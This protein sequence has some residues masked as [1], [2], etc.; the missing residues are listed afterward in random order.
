M[1]FYTTLAFGTAAVAQP[2]VGLLS[3]SLIRW[4]WSINQARKTVQ[5]GLQVLSATIIVT[6]LDRQCR[7]RHLL[8]GAGDLR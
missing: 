8:H 7:G 2:F 1:G 4:G 6:G 5:V 3:D